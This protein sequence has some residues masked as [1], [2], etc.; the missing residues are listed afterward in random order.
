MAS[1]SSDSDMD[2]FDSGI[3]PYSFEPEYTVEEIQQRRENICGENSLS[4]NEIDDGNMDWCCCLMCS[5]DTSIVEK[6][7]CKSPKILSDEQFGNES[8]ITGTATF[9][10]ICLDK[11]VLE[12][13]LEGW[14]DL[15]GDSRT[16]DNKNYR[17]IA[18]RQ[19]ILW[20][21][22]RVGRKNRIPLP[23]CVLRKIREVFPDPD[24]IYVPFSVAE[25]VYM[26]FN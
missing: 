20:C 12:V 5:H 16:Y 3:E 1:E 6:V 22:G 21:H 9:H 14:N 26:S 18:Y 19:F 4:Q 10:S 11:D 13:A 23:N 15:Q 7:C 8:C 25:T 17:F 2:I 24:N